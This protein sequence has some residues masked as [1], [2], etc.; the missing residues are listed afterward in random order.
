MNKLIIIVGLVIAVLLIVPISTAATVGNTYNVN[1]YTNSQ[2][3]TDTIDIIYSNAS[4]A[5]VRAN[6]E[7][8]ASGTSIYY[9]NFTGQTEFSVF[10]YQIITVIIT[11]GNTIVYNHTFNIPIAP[12]G[13]NA[14]WA[15]VVAAIFGIVFT[16]VGR[17]M[18]ETKKRKRIE[19][20]IAS[21]ND[22]TEEAKR[23]ALDVKQGERDK[24]KR[25]ELLD[26]LYREHYGLNTETLRKLWDKAKSLNEDESM[27]KGVSMSTEE[28]ETFENK[29]T[30]S[31]Q[32][33][34]PQINQIAEWLK[35]KKYKEGDSDVQ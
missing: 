29:K 21:G 7:V 9:E 35:Q 6:V 32:V 2:S 14:N 5:N 16:W 18:Y 24:M 11:V 31:E 26:Q 10:Q 34:Q 13:L 8:L 12:A 27:D 4:Y 22:I 28:N 17:G 1:V 20:E 33:P 19:G 23:F 15:I 3:K 30:L 25:Y